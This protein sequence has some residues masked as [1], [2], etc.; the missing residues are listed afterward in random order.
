MTINS[1]S[2]RTHETHIYHVILQSLIKQFRNKLYTY[3][4]DIC[5]EFSKSESIIYLRKYIPAIL[6]RF[7]EYKNKY[8]NHN[9]KIWPFSSTKIPNTSIRPLFNKVT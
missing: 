7:A 5:Q 8:K 2:T 4:V 6:R 3:L 9:Y 1:A